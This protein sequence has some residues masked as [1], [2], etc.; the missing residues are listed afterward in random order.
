MTDL[1]NDAAAIDAVRESSNLELG[2]QLAA[3]EIQ[4]FPEFWYVTTTESGHPLVGGT[5]FVVDRATATVTQVPASRPPRLNCAD[6]RRSR[7][8]DA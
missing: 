1:I 7:S 5:A 8:L 6:I 3:A 4:G 2:V